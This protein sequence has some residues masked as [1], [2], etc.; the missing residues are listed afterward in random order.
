MAN[1]NL[2]ELPVH[3]LKAVG[4]QLDEEIETYSQSYAHLRSALLKFQV[5][6]QCIQ[7]ATDEESLIPLTNSLYVTG[8]LQNRLM[9][10]IGT[11]YFVEKDVKEA[12]EFYLRKTEYLKNSLQKLENTVTQRQGQKRVLVS[13]LENKLRSLAVKN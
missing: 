11:G 2:E 13:V 7:K 3:Q 5:S 8:K 1:I 9:V 4:K 10:D 12:N 6:L